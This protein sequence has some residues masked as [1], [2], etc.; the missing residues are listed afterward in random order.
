LGAESRADIEICPK[1]HG[2]GRVLHEQNSLFGRI[3]TETTCSNCRGTG[4]IIKNKCKTCNGE[5]R[6]RTTSRVK[7]KIPAGIEDGQGLKLTGYGEAGLKGGAPGDL[8]INITV[9][10]HEIFERDG[11]DIHMEMPITFSQAALGAT[12]SVPTLTGPVSLKIPA[13]TQTGTK[14]KL[15]RKGITNSRTGAVGNQYVIA[16]VVTPTH[17]SSEQKEIF[18]RLSKTNE[19]SES[20]FDKIKKFFS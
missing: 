13:G 11:L 12:I 6:V 8:Y 9:Q 16:K 2:R 5:G 1:C 15:A 14:F 19:K 17:L 4:E 18:T 10:P 3:Q 7:V 20:F